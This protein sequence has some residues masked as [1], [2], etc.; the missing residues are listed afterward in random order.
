MKMRVIE[1]NVG[2]QNDVTVEMF[3]SF[4][5]TM[6]D[7][8]WNGVDSMIASG[9]RGGNMLEIGPGPGYVGLEIGKKLAPDSLTGCEI[10]PAMLQFAR[11]NA[12]NYGIDARYVQG[13]CMEMPFED[14]SFDSVISNGSLHEWETPGNSSRIYFLLKRSL[15]GGRNYRASAQLRFK[16]S[17]G[18][19]R[20]LW[21]VYFGGKEVKQQPPQYLSLRRLYAC[22]SKELKQYHSFPIIINLTASALLQPSEQHLIHQERLNLLTD[23]PL[24]LPGS[25]FAAHAF[26]RQVF[27]ARS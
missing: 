9:L 5:R 21:T 23:D 2:I 25:V 11:K 13:N 24:N 16:R 3:D 8:G 19:D 14:E 18:N 12:K 1:T 7:R 22:S 27:P 20:F 10:S 4:A 26:R 15:Y 17:Y 6:R